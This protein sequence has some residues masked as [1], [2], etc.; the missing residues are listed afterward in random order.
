M[1]LNISEFRVPSPIVQRNS[2][3]CNVFRVRYLLPSSF[4]ETI[5]SNTKIL[6]EE[7]VLFY[8][9]PSPKQQHLATLLWHKGTLSSMNSFAINLR[10]LW[11][12]DCSAEG[13][14]PGQPPVVRGPA[15]VPA[16]EKQL[17]KEHVC[18]VQTSTGQA[19]LFS[20]LREPYVSAIWVLFI[21]SPSRK[22]LTQFRKKPESELGLSSLVS[23]LLGA[24]RWLQA[25]RPGCFSAHL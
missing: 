22:Q 5:S 6:K 16:A 23:R 3:Y 21:S 9:F 8:N 13:G 18:H 11:E 12:S 20:I 24:I 17:T 25:R 15:R 2:L 14:R 4:K 19:P 10:W 1:Q 7:T